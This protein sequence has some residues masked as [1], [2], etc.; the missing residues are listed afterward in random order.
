MKTGDFTGGFDPNIVFY[1]QIPYKFPKRIKEEVD[2][3]N[4][5]S[6]RAMCGSDEKSLPLRVAFA[7]A[8]AGDINAKKFYFCPGKTNAGKSKLMTMFSNCF[9]SFVQ[10]FQAENLA[11]NEKSGQDEAQKNRWAYLIRYARIIYSNEANM[12]K[13]LDGNAIKKVSSGG[14]KM[15]GRTHHA[16]E[17][18]FVPHFTPF[19]ML[20]DI[21]EISPLDDA[22]YG[23]LVYYEFEKQFVEKPTE[24]YHIAMDPKLDDKIRSKKF[25][26]GFTH[27]MLDAYNYYLKHGQPEFD[28]RAKEEWTAE[29]LKDKNLAS[30]IEESFNIT[31]DE[32]DYILA[33][34]FT[35]FRNRNK[36][37]FSTISNKRFAEVLKSM[38]VVPGRVGKKGTRVW[39]G[40]QKIV[41]IDDDYNLV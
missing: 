22:V 24:D 8:L 5:I 29:G 18:S 17:E 3:A 28:Q 27:L 41:A 33:T 2:Y 30:I 19:C 26:R 14:D 23:R 6:F 39:K 38:G 40:I 1:H 34:E 11:Y 37:E 15:T 25:I 9:G 32:K 20:N 7:R 36:K 16:E 31:K 35:E 13:T 21:P 4:K 10:Q 12:K